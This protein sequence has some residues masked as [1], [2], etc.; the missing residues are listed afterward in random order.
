MTT[1]HT[2]L[3]SP[4]HPVG[5]KQALI[6]GLYALV[7]LYCLFF[8]PN[9]EMFLVLLIP[10]VLLLFF[11]RSDPMKWFLLA[12]L[13]IA[14]GYNELTPA[15]IPLLLG[16]IFLFVAY[17]IYFLAK[18]ATLDPIP[19]MNLFLW[20]VMA[21]YIAQVVSIFVSIHVHGQHTM[22]A[23]REAHKFFVPVLFP[24]I[25]LDWYSKPGWFDRLLKSLVV[26]LLV[27]SVYGAYQFLSGAAWS[28]GEV[29]SGY[30]IAGR[31]YATFRGGAN[32]Y[33]GFLELVV[34]TV[35]AAAFHFKEKNWRI[36]CGVAVILG[37]LNG[38]YTY[39][40]GGFLTISL[41]CLA[42][43][44][45]RFR[46]VVWVPFFA[47]ILFVGVMAGN[48]E[49][50]NRQLVML[51]DPSSVAIEATVLHRYVTYTGFIRD[52]KANPVTGVGWGAAEYFSSGSSLYSFWEVRHQ[53]S[54]YPID[55]FGGLNSLIF[56]M[57]LKGGAAS[58]LSLLL[59]LTATVYVSLRAVRAKEK[60][61]DLAVGI[62]AGIAGFSSHQLVDNL[63]QWPQTGTFF[64]ILLG[65]LAVLGM[66]SA[67]NSYISTDNTDDRHG[68]ERSPEPLRE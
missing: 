31:A 15:S 55:Y 58:G 40:R 62:V 48:A 2:I 64:W 9:T 49:K 34:P 38:L 8:L 22:N 68:R 21:S 12:P 30:A 26:T 19:R 23:I 61:S 18:A 16:V 32:A 28:I 41:S 6:A 27:I 51:T 60:R 14:L 4:E 1:Q 46:K 47:T 53:R 56:D 3:Y 39:S 57:L 10:G 20:L 33:A 17:L 24:L 37:I 11:A 29:A 5:G 35:L 36:L 65:M 45:Y 54:I 42:Y 7:I 59:L 43:T 52:I 25:I 13:A 63:L 50:F 66:K 44:F 67:D